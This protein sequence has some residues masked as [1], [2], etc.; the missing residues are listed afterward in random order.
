MSLITS[1]DEKISRKFNYSSLFFL[2]RVKKTP[3]KQ[4]FV[5]TNER[6]VQTGNFSSLA[7]KLTSDT[8]DDMQGNVCKLWRLIFE[9]LIEGR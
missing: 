1:G 5:E 6:S 4:K 3:K 2:L 7:F 9:T 8:I